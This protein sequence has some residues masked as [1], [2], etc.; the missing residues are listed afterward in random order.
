[1]TREEILALLKEMKQ[2][3]INGAVY[4]D[5]KRERKFIALDEAIKELE[6][7]TDYKRAF[8]IA[9][10]LLN[11]AILY[12]VDTDKIYEI[13][14]NKDGMVDNESYEEYIL[15]HMDEL[16]HG[17]YVSQVESEETDADKAES[18]AQE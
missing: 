13:I 11:G 4:D 7:M 9:C 17:Q 12:G 1:M 8:K 15:S 2:K 5:T 6:S 18:E 16:D 10:E 14:M 3:T